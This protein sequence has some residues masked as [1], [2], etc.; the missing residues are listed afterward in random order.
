MSRSCASCIQRLAGYDDAVRFD[1]SAPQAALWRD[2]LTT[3]LGDLGVP[4]DAMLEL[5]IRP[6][7]EAPVARLQLDLRWAVHEAGRHAHAEVL[8]PLR[9]IDGV[10]WSGWPAYMA[11]VKLLR[12]LA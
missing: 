8:V 9:R 6:H 4:P 7:G 1:P 2:W 11:G 3:A 12:A 5:Q 10:G